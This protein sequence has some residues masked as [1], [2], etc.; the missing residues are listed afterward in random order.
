MSSPSKPNFPSP[1]SMFQDPFLQSS[2]Q[3]L[4]DTGQ[5]LRQGKFLDPNDPTVG[6]LN[7]L[8]ALNPQ[9]SQTAF[10]LATRDRQRVMDQAYRQTINE[11]EAS[12]QYT[13]SVTGNRLADLN[14]SFS[15]D[16][17]DIASQIYIADVERSLANVS[18]LFG[19]G[20]NTLNAVGGT[21]L[22]NQQQTNDFNTWQWNAQVELENE[23]FQ[24]Q[25]AQEAAQAQMWGTF[26]GP[27]GGAIAGSV[28][29]GP[30]AGMAGLNAGF[31]I[32]SMVL[33][34]M[35]GNPAGMANSM[36]QAS[37]QDPL[38]Q[39]LLNANA[40]RNVGLGTPS[41]GGLV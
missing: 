12:G 26:T 19:T 8:V 32:P 15:R 16:I 21:G 35:S 7:Q 20:L 14:E 1:P 27:V 34:A 30:Q 23:R 13:S 38:N 36:P 4:S 2:Q 25:Q 5:A 31:T 41:S 17:S 29:G 24:R 37:G 33:S 22:K 39:R 3:G 6:F 28:N 9:A 18:S 10:D 11:L 40:R